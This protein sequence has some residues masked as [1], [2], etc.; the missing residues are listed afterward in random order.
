MHFP[1]HPNLPREGV[2]LAELFRAKG[3]R[4]DLGAAHAR[5][6]A[7]AEGVGLPFNPPHFA[8]D[9][10]LAQELSVWAAEQGQRGLHDRLFRAVFVDGL[11]VGD[12]DVLVRL[13]REQGLDPEAAAAVLRDRSHRAKVDADWQYAR[14]L[15]VTGVPTYVIGRRGVVGAQPYE[16][17]ERLAL[18]A[19][20]TPRASA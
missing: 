6:A 20:A 13:A 2:P 14:E 9:T 10:R 19:G 17:L 5:L 11:N 1:L 12:P 18:Q 8:W 15:G 7:V 16:A 3:M 4:F